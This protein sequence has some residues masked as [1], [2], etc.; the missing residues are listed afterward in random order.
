MVVLKMMPG[1]RRIIKSGEHINSH[2]LIKDA[3]YFHGFGIDRSLSNRQTVMNGDRCKRTRSI[4]PHVFFS[5]SLVFVLVKRLSKF[6]ASLLS[7]RVFFLHIKR[8][9]VPP[10]VQHFYGCLFSNFYG[11]YYA[12][13]QGTKIIQTTPARK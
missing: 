7:L 12:G 1:F 10:S 11:Y 9:R 5:F 4:N 2:A 3:C 13:L 6:L 8:I